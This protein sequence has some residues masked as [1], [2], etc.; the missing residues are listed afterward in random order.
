M[1]FKEVIGQEDV[2][3]LLIQEVKSGRIPHAKLITGDEGV[4]K[5]PLALAYAQYILCTNRGENDACGVCPA[6]IK[7]AKLIHPDLHFSFPTV[8]NKFCN[9]YMPAWRK[10]IMSSPYFS[11]KH[12]LSEMGAENK[13][14]LIYTGETDEVIKKLTLKPYESDYKVMIIWSVDRQNA[15]S[16]NRLLKTLEEPSDK[17]VL[18]LISEYPEK[19]LP[20]ILSRTQQINIRPIDEQN[21]ENALQQGYGVTSGDSKTIAHLSGGNF[22][23]ALEAIH[24]NEDNKLYFELFVNLMRLSYQRKIRE[25]KLWSEQV[26]GLGRE[27][28][29]DLL[30]FCQRLI[31]EN[32]IYN[33]HRQELNYMTVDESN[34]ATRFAPFVNER[35]VM[36]IMDELT[37]AQQHI[38]QNVN[39]KIVFFDF[40]LK[41]IVLLK[42]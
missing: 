30:L 1:L 6:C 32:F 20:T 21:I 19:I 35:N 36:G 8:N 2:K 37:E 15:E 40:S 3:R 42:Q 38:E 26:A 23:K 33:F 9:Y 39:A 34:F 27:R 10:M 41:M 16:A 4:G 28:Q 7:A 11:M 24:I 22:V 29:K 18:I 5:M 14:A 12:W 13:Q 25:M 31:R 17:T